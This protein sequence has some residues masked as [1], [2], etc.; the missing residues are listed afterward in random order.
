MTE[1]HV[2][3]SL[4][5]DGPWPAGSVGLPLPG[6]ELR[7]ARPDGQPAAAGEVGAVLIRGPNLF[8]EYWRNPEATSKAFASGWFDTGD[9]GS[10]DEHGFLTLAGRSND[11]IIT[12]G[13]NVYPPVVERVVNACPGVREC[14]VAGLPDPVRGERVVAFV[15]RDDPALDEARLQAFCAERLVDYQRPRQVFFVESL[16]RNTLGKVLRRELVRDV[17]GRSGEPSRTA[18]SAARLGGFPTTGQVGDLPPRP[19]LTLASRV[20]QLRPTTINR[21][22]AEARQVQQS[23]ASLVSLMRGQPDTPTPAPIVEAVARAVRGGR[24]GYPDNQGEPGL[25]QAVAEKL[26]RDNGLSY[27][28]GREILVTDGATCGISTALAALVEPGSAVLLPEPIYDAYASP[29]A[30]WQGRPVFVRSTIRDGRFIIDRAALEAAWTPDARV[31]LLN[32]PWNPV[33]TVFTRAEL[34]ELIGFALERGLTVISDE[35]Y[36]ALVYDRRLHVSPAS[37]WLEA[38]QRTVLVNSLSKTYA[39]TGWRVGYCAGPAEVIQAMLLV[40]QQ[41]SRGPAT[42]VQDAAAFALRAD[43]SW[44]REMAAEYQARRDLVVSRLQGIPGVR[45]LVPKGGLFV[46]VDVR[47]LGRPADEVRR[48]LL[49]EAGVVVL[50]GSAFGPGGEGT[51]RISFAAGGAVLEQGLERLRAGLL[52]L[53][54]SRP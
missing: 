22:L 17:A 25:R 41:S 11:L 26:R 37:L 3:T 12:S 1:A 49:H 9:L 16:P 13:Y 54:E 23:G 32:T 34:A 27:D 51:L 48:F 52:R 29:I 47:A 10:L 8:R 43:Q 53:A 19:Q 39:M 6:I 50:H 18:S 35:I 5:L 14:A 31:L 45:P 7:V 20:G 40:L 28:P 15:V 38:R 42:F 44:L 2:I 4:P 21:V 46:M 30:L 33:G 24:T 36:E